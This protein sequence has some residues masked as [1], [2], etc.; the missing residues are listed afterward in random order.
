MSIL[1]LCQNLF[2]RIA[3]ASLKYLWDLQKRMKRSLFHILNGCAHLYIRPKGRVMDHGTVELYLWCDHWWLSSPRLGD[4]QWI[5]DASVS[6]CQIIHSSHRNFVC[7][8][9]LMAETTVKRASA[10]IGFDFLYWDTRLRLRWRY[11]CA[12]NNVKTPCTGIT[13]D[14]PPGKVGTAV[15]RLLPRSLLSHSVE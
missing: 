11:F 9:S 12:V 1:A 6:F 15:A 4:Q 7:Q 2:I 13:P 5:L 3:F 14:W 10:F 8:P